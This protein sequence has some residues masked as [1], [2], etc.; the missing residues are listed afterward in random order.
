MEVFPV[1]RMDDALTEQR[2]EERSGKIKR[3]IAVRR[4]E[5]FLKKYR[6]L[7][8]DI[9][10]VTAKRFS[11]RCFSVFSITIRQYNRFPKGQDGAQNLQEF[12]RTYRLTGESQDC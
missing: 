7:K 11:R 12:S 6:G 8:Q 1:F 3:G 9:L 10:T 5:G 2:Q 4:G